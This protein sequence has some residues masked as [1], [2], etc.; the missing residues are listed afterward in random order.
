MVA[1]PPSPS[2]FSQDVMMQLMVSTCNKN[3][4]VRLMFFKN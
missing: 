2:S 3:N 4:R 1:V